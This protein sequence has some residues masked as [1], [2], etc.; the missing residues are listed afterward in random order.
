MLKLKLRKLNESSN[1]ISI[2]DFEGKSQK[3]N[4]QWS[5]ENRD[6]RNKFW[7]SRCLNIQ[8]FSF[9]IFLSIYYIVNNFTLSYFINTLFSLSIVCST[10]LQLEFCHA[11]FEL[12][13]LH[14]QCRLL[15]FKC[16]NLLLNPWIFCLLM[17]IVPFHF[18]FYFEVLVSESL[19]DVLGL[20][21]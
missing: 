11:S 5:Y 17:R 16:S 13:Q 14:I 4:S 18:F 2:L 8:S 1:F 15:T 9:C 7:I 19:T 21:C 3:N 20:H 6:V 12:Q 10:D